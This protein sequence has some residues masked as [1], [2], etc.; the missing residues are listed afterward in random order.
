MCGTVLPPVAV[1]SVDG[2]RHSFGGCRAAADTRGGETGAEAGGLPGHT[3]WAQECD[4]CSQ[5]EPPSS[6]KVVDGAVNPTGWCK[7]YVKKP[8][9]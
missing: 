8:A 1:A 5:F 3:A 6:C 2:W 9:A 4:N 7:V